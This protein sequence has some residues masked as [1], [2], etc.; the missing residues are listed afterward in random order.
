MS[1]LAYSEGFKSGGF[2]ARSNNPTA[3]PATVCV[4]PNVPKGCLPAASV[5]SFEFKDEQS[6]SYEAGLKSRFAH[7]R[8]EVNVD[9]YYTHYKD[10][11]VST[12]DGVLGYNV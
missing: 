11:Q 8:A 4:T 12:F 2:D 10:L 6:N 3:P 7:D 9:Y 1:Y 5:G